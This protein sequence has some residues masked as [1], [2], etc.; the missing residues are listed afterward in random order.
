[1]KRTWHSSTDGSINILRPVSCTNNN[2]LTRSISHQPCKTINSH[3]NI[4]NV[5]SIQSKRRLLHDSLVTFV[6]KKL[7]LFSLITG[8]LCYTQPVLWSS[9]WCR[10]FRRALGLYAFVTSLLLH[11]EKIHCLLL[12]RLNHN[13]VLLLWLPAYFVTRLISIC[14]ILLSYISYKRYI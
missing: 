6:Y 10:N 1:M 5:I 3:Q 13:C 12:H 14:G 2:N 11:V 4:I 8:L 9:I 7:I